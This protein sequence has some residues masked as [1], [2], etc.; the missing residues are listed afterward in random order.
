VNGNSVND[1]TKA[2]VNRV[3]TT[4]GVCFFN[5]FLCL[6]IFCSFIQVNLSI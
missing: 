6:T 2:P 4:H 5:I 1:R 3:L